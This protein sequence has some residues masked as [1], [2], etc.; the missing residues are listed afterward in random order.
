MWHVWL[1]SSCKVLVEK[2]GENRAAE[3]P[4]H[5]RENNIKKDIKERE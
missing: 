5:I 4:K 1:E 3:M 2:P